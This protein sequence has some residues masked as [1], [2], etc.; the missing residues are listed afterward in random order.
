MKGLCIVRWK[1][2]AHVDRTELNE[3]WNRIAAA[4]ERY[5]DVE[6]AE[7]EID[8]LEECVV[9]YLDKAIAADCGMDI[10]RLEHAPVFSDEM[11]EKYFKELAD[12]AISQ[13]FQDSDED[14]YWDRAR[15]PM[16]LEYV[17]TMQSE[18]RQIL[19]DGGDVPGMFLWND[20]TTGIPDAP[21]ADTAHHAAATRALMYKLRYSA[22]A[23]LPNDERQAPFTSKEART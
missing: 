7:F 15:Q 16:W 18:S 13:V 10:S 4:T 12:Q 19:D 23:L 14:I 22:W 2:L 21:H 3:R 1:Y 5:P 6:T 17:Q 8:F 9:E 20:G 11:H